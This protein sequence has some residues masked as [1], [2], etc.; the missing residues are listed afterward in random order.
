MSNYSEKMVAELTAQASWT[1]A[2]ACAFAEANGL[3]NRSVISKIKSLGL[4]YETKP[5]AVT[6]R[7][8]PVVKKAQFVESIQ[9]ALG[10]AVPSLMKLTKADLETL[11]R[12]VGAEMPKPQ[13]EEETA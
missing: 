7:G 5:K 9:A 8:E 11:T 13:E 6:K 1:Y 4:E 2:Q 12:A 3:K 10:V